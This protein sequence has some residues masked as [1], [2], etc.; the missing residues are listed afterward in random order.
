[1]ASLF[2]D[3]RKDRFVRPVT[4]RQLTVAENLSIQPAD[5]AVG[6]RVQIGADQWLF[7]RSL[8]PRATVRFWVITWSAKCSWLGS[9]PTEKWSGSWRSN[10]DPR[11][12]RTVRQAF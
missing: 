10:S 11:G 9:A 1:M 2:I 4:W 3:L 8:A 5:V 7:Y 12:T 6:Y